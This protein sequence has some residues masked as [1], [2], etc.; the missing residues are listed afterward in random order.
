MTYTLRITD[1][2][3]GVIGTRVMLRESQIQIRKINPEEGRR[4]RAA[5]SAKP[6][7][8]AKEIAGIFFI[9]WS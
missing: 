8:T 2:Y 3:R 4:I 1:F 5:V 9:N 7:T 6:I